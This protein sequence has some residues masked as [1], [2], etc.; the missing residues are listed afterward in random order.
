MLSYLFRIKQCATVSDSWLAS[1]HQQLGHAY[2]C[3]LYWD[4]P[5]VFRDSANPAFHEAIG[6]TISLS[7]TTPEHLMKI[8]LLKSYSEDKLN[9]R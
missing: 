1:T 2:Y 9:G 3:L 5:F 8:G 6:A 4:K 7:L